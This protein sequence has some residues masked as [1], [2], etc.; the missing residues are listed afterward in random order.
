MGDQ[1]KKR[2]A[3]GP[4]RSSLTRQLSVRVPNGMYA[5]LEASAAPNGHRSGGG[6]AG[7]AVRRMREYGEVG[8]ARMRELGRRAA[9]R[10]HADGT[11]WTAG[12]LLDELLR[13]EDAPPLP[14][15]VR[16]LCFLA[17]DAASVSA[18]LDALRPRG[19]V[20][21]VEAYQRK[22]GSYQQNLA[23]ADPGRAGS[24]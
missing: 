20:A 4:T 7:E 21:S 16:I 5:D 6:V 8:P 2:H 15:G 14:E 11:T 22:D 18:G 17:R 24:R 1:G 23:L 12:E 19:I 3:S 13:L 10:S 9:A